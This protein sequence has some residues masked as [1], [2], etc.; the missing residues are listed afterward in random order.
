LVVVERVKCAR[1]I[2]VQD[3]VTLRDNSAQFNAVLNRLNTS[4]HCIYWTVLVV[5]VSHIKLLAYVKGQDQPQ[6]G[7]ICSHSSLSC[8][9]RFLC[10]W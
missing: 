8:I 5:A 1:P 3:A 9:L 7:N 2:H 4:P 6:R 10:D